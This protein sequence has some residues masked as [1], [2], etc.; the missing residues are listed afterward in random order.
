[1]ISLE[2]MPQSPGTRRSRSPLWA[3]GSAARRVRRTCAA[4]HSN[5]RPGPPEHV[6]RAADCRARAEAP[7][8]AAGAASA[9]C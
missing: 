2:P 7:S 1:M 3:G 4:A 8:R 9:D 5:S 6:P